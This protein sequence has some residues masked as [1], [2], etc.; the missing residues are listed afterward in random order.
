WAQPGL[1]AIEVALFRLLESLGVRPHFVLGHSVGEVAAA[2]VAGVLSLDD[3]CRLVA[4]RGRL[5]EA[6]PAGG[7]MVAVRAGE[8][9]VLPLL[10]EHVGLAAVNGPDSVVISGVEDAV[11]Q[12]AQQLEAQGHRTRRLAVSHAFHSPLMEPMLAEFAAVAEDLSY[13]RPQIPF[14][15]TLTGGLVS[16]EIADPGYWVRHVRE[17]VRFADGITELAAQGVGMFLEVGPDAV[18]STMAEDCLSDDTDAVLVPAQRRDRNEPHTLLTALGRL[19]THGL[20]IDW[21]GTLTGR[22]TRHIDLPTY[23]FQRQ[24]YWLDTKDY[25]AESW[26]A[27]DLGTNPAALGVTA[28]DHPLLSA[29]ITVP[30]TGAMVL[31]GRLSVQDQPWLADHDVLGSVLLPGT[32]FVELALRAAE[33]VGCERI[34]ELTLTGP[35]VLP[36]DDGVFVRVLVGAPDESGRR[37]VSVHSR[38]EQEPEDR[39]VLHAEGVLAPGAPGAS[40]ASCDLTAWPPPGATV[41]PTE[42]AYALLLGRGYGYGPAFQGLRAAWER[43]DELFAEVVLPEEAHADARRCGLHPALLDA[44]MHASL[45]EDLDGSGATVLP[46]SW[47]GVSR[48]ATGATALRVRMAPDGPDS[49]TV[50][51]ADHAGRPVL[52]VTSLV[53]RTVS[54]QQLDSV[55]GARDAT[56][57]RVQWQPAEPP[58]QPDRSRWAVAGSLDL[59]V[60]VFAGLAELGDALD[61]GSVD[62]PDVV[63]LPVGASSGDVPADARAATSAALRAVRSWLADERFADSRLVIVTRKAVTARGHDH[64][65]PAGAPIWGL[66]RAAQAEN[67]GRF[68]LVDLDDAAESR[69]AL[70]TALVSDEPECALRD[71]TLLVPR[72][73]TAAP[74]PAEHLVHGTALI[75]GGTGGLGALVARHLVTVH[76]IRSLVLTSRRGADAP[77]AAG[78]VAELTAL[79]AEVTT[80][81]CD[82]ADRAALA[83]VLAAIPAEHPLTVV[84][85]A[86]GTVDN[87]VVTRL[88]Q[89]RLEATLRPK[90]DGA[91]HLHELTADL[92]LSAFVL[93]SSAGGLVLSAGQGAYAAANVFLD[94]L[95][96]H[97]AA[98]GLPAT[99]L[100]YGLWG[101]DTGFG[102]ALTEDDLARMAQQGFPALTAAEGLAAFDAALSGPATLVPI[103]IDPA[104]IRAGGDVPPLLRGVVRMPR[105]PGAAAADSALSAR[106]SGLT[107]DERVRLLLD[108][109]RTEV[110]AVLGHASA[111]AVEPDRAFSEIGFDSLT[112]VELRNRLK[113]ATGLRLPATLVF[114]HPTARA[115]A[116]HLDHA[117]RGT[118]T[119]T[120]ARVAT[121]VDDEPIAIVGMAC[122]YPGGVSSPEDLWGL[123]A[124]GVDAVVPLPEDR[125]WDEDLYDAEPGAPGKCYAQGGGFLHNAGDFDAGFFGIGP[126]EASAMDPQQRLLLE[127]SWEAFERAGIDPSSLKGSATGVFVGLMYHDYG[128]GSSSGG[129]AVAGRV[130]YVLGLEGPSVAVDTACSSSLVALHSAVQALRSGECSLA[131]AGGVAVMA[132]PEILVEFSRQR[133]LSPGGRCKSFASAADGTGWAEGAGVLVVER[134][135]DARRNGHPVLAI[136]RGSAVNQDGASNGFFAPNGPSQQR[137]IAGALASAG[138]TSADV[139]VVEGHGTG[140]TLGDPIEAQALLATY[141]QG[142]SSDRPLWLGSIKSNIG[143]AQAAAGVAGIIKMVQ[144]MRHGVLPRTLHVDEPSSQVDWSSG[145]VE[146]LTEAREWLPVDGRP[147]RAGVSSFGLTGTNAH[148]IVEE[149]DAAVGDADEGAGPVAWVLSARSP[150]ALAEQAERLRVFAE[151]VPDGELASVARALVVGRARFEH[152]AVV[153]GADRAALMRELAGVAEAVP[154]AKGAGSLACVFTGQGSQRLGMG[155]EL[156][157]AFPVFAEAFDAVVEC[158]DGHLGGVSLRDVVWGADAGLVER[159]G[160]AQPG[161]FAIEVA[162]FR[163][164]ESLGVRPHFVLGHSVGEVAAAH[165]AGVLSLDDACRLVAARGRLMEALPAGGVMVAVRAGEAQVLPLVNEHVGLAAV[166]GPDSV[167]ISGAEDAVSQVVER[168][169]A[170]GHRTRRLAVSHAFH[171]PLMEPMLAEFAA[172][173]EDLSYARPQIP[174]VSTLTGGLVGEEIADPGYWVRHVREPVRFADGITELAAQG[175]G[176]FLE[177]GPDAVLSTMA[178]DCLSD[179]TDAVLVPAQ[180]RDRNEPHTLLTALGRLH[181]HGL[182]IDWPGTLTGRRT[183]HIDLPTYPFQRQR[184]WQ[185]E[186]PAS[187]GPGALGLVSAEHPLLGAAVPLAGSDAV[188]FTGRLSVQTHPWLADHEVG[189]STLFPG[190]GFVEL[191]LAAG[192]QAG[193]H[194]LEELVLAAPLIMPEQGA[195][196]IQVS[197]GAPDDSGARTVSVHSRTDDTLPWTRHADGALGAGTRPDTA[198]LSEWPPPGAVTVPV[199]DAYATM[200]SRG[201]GYGPVFRGL[202]AAWQ[203]GDELFAEV[204]LPEQAH[205]DAGRFAL[206]PALL[207]ASLHVMGVARDGLG[208]GDGD[209]GGATVLPFSWSGVA[210]HAHGAHGLRVRITPAGDRAVALDLADLSG[211]PVASI[212][213]LALREITAEQLAA[214]R[215]GHDAL[216]RIDWTPVTPVA[217]GRPVPETSG[218]ATVG[219]GDDCAYADVAALAAAAEAGAP[220][221][222]VVVWR[223]A[224]AASG[225]PDDVRA[226]VAEAL[227]AVQLWL[228]DPRFTAST[229]VITTEG[230][231]NSDD[232][233]VTLHQAP[234]WGLVR[235][236]QAENPGRFVLADID[237]TGASALGAAVASGEPELMIRAGRVLVPRLVREPQPADAPPAA[238]V[239]LDP[240]APPAAP[241][242]L[243]PHGTV[244]ITGGTGG[245]GAIVAKHLVTAHGIRHL[246]LT[247]RRGP[248]APGAARLRAELAELGADA[249]V[250][251]CDVGDRDALAAVLAGIGPAAPLTAVVHAAGAVDDGVVGSLTPQRIE[252]ALCSKVDGAWHL[253]ELT[254]DLPLAAFVML[255]SAGGLVLAA[256]QGGYAAANVFLDALAGHRVARG[257]PATSLAYG[258]WDTDAGLGQWLT[259][260]DLGRLA[261]QGFPVLTVEDGLAAFDAALTA[262]RA[263]LVPVKVDVAALRSR[264]GELPAL[265][266]GLVPAARRRDT[267]GTADP[268]GLARR[269]AALPEAEQERELTQLVRAHAAAVLGHASGDDIDPERDFLEI[270]FDSLAA[271]ELRNRLTT[272]TGLRLSPLAVFDNKNAAALARSLRADLTLPAAAQAPAE[273]PDT[274]AHLFRAAV[275][276]D[277]VAGGFGLLRAVADLR[278]RFTCAADFGPGPE[279]VRL[280]DGPQEPIVIGIS[281]PMAT[282]GPHQHARLA[283]A[284]RG[285]RPMITL[286]NPGFGAGDPLPDS[287]DAVVDHLSEAV[288]RTAAGRPFVLVGYSSGGTLAYATAGSLERVRGVRPAGVVLMDTFRVDLEDRDQGR[289]MEQLTIGLVEKDTAYGMFHSSALSAM[290][291][292][293]DLVPRFRLDPVGAPVLFVGATESFMPPEAGAGDDD[294]W[295]ARPWDPAHHFVGVRAT[296]FSMIEEQAAEA[297]TV[298]EEWISA[299]APRGA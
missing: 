109:V 28:L 6:L 289:L 143:H 111:Q 22:R 113:T 136:V 225:V 291:R 12:V 2:H 115:T 226:T 36:D 144:A 236:A 139:D 74:A 37:T 216:F 105:R 227:A 183:R 258:L 8:A 27:Q 241:V 177:V 158:L 141:G 52:S 11:S 121:G 85:H 56:L 157:G 92:P 132:T 67:P 87:G 240:D 79:G 245:L 173:A 235:A 165:V 290:N 255:S 76:G 146:L 171:S 127:T 65:D 70:P 98:Q 99:S 73:V 124:D 163:L 270:G 244:L 252:T 219:R 242:P 129:S 156:Y 207:D 280:A 251:A 55:R 151:T 106:L 213:S 1:F 62:V 88:D 194:V 208:D 262:S 278:P 116:E 154:V 155:R 175:V 192:E 193:C 53:S 40:D 250:V 209:G 101:V 267:A 96:E 47:N 69:A 30:D 130:S 230:A 49:V 199:G 275:L 114:D 7:V 205:V 90:V 18:L 45:L 272:A 284:F 256:G 237:G 134:L 224:P 135:S 102:A 131:L 140:T 166:N 51:V 172:V 196:T 13:A 271:V 259:E 167:V 277:N 16:E 39:W 59:G 160:W 103:K 294:S 10:N 170:Q 48:Y 17:P 161:L 119:N 181:T 150:E 189:G 169:E 248:D 218:W 82:V 153:V 221:P 107:G 133:G 118:T 84:V 281:T 54:A 274:L 3:A 234:V 223:A 249:R 108:L 35:L 75:T 31:T 200:L 25:L 5:M 83:A 19:H 238:P 222:D 78:L 204:V 215:R 46:F 23:P 33:E 195:A 288:L 191:A 266:R 86:A 149:G 260:A 142:R 128:Y 229:L 100:A 60:P 198:R 293:F 174:F 285:K 201:Y 20:D 94:G 95:A 246:V 32:G 122:R 231:M 63:L 68:V 186:R 182:D 298:V 217:S 4:A 297:G 296:H 254:A 64:T 265:L 58:A 80:A 159:T 117:L 110:A 188:V 91:W 24:R 14:V 261:R 61:S 282:G 93:F 50:D 190:T 179:D 123:V 72:L 168:L 279:G 264:S 187:A 97:R 232:T 212:G 57:Y 164:L 38:A 71:G 152:R 44:A 77:G 253:H 243:D 147:R 112:A 9:Q 292:Y 138:L 257:L 125:G 185:P 29:A 197:L 176:V 295:R 233:E 126:N 239:P 268:G 184:Y 104:G 120:P 220:A 178:E 276:S 42:G 26:L 283:A 273:A 203:R 206:H 210:V 89:N 214:S 145:A 228:A 66:V 269:L 180:R 287:T 15:S 211:V 43:G 247:S 34:E 299:H 148:V 137:V 81:T 202:T 162:L 41:R 21:P 286:P 263:T